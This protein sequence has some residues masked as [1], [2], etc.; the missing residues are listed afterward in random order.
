MACC[1]L[2]ALMSGSLIPL[3]SEL[4]GGGIDSLINLC[5]QFMQF[6]EMCINT[7]MGLFDDI[8]ASIGNL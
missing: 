6:P 2:I 7:G 4:L 8:M 5:A 1:C 3:I